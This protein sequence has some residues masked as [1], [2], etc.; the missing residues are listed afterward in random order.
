MLQPDEACIMYDLMNGHQ[1]SILVV[2]KKY[3]QV[4]FHSDD[5]F[6]GTIKDKYLDRM[7]K[8]HRDRSGRENEKKVDGEQRV[9]SADFQKVTQLTRKFFESPGMA[10]EVL[11]E[12]LKGYYR[13]LILPVANRLTTVKKLLISPNDVLNFIPFEALQSQD[14]KYLVEKYDVKYMHST[15]VLKQIRER[16][17]GERSKPLLAMGGA[18][19]NKMNIDQPVISSQEDLN[20]LV[21]EV[22]ENE[23]TNK[24]ERKAYAALFG[25]GPMNALPGTV[26]EV[27]NISKIVPSADFYLGADMSENRIKAMAKSGDLGKYKILHLATHGFVVN[28][29][30]DLSGVAMSIFETEQGGEDGFLNVNEISALNLK[31]D[32]TIL[33]A[34]QTALGKIYSGEGVTGLTQS[35]IIAGSNGALVSLWPVSDTSTMLFM[36]DLY[37][38]TA[39]GKPYAQVVNEI[40]RKFIKGE[41]GKENKHPNF[42]AP[43]V[44]FGN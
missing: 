37:K 5:N 1:I 42:W 2:T 35:L 3:A 15:S 28:E 4:I 36:S 25:Q 8:E 13:F 22:E 7:N 14:G 24:S 16:Q 29:I 20:M 10:D 39:A 18:Q 41:F 9:S 27:K 6:I 17:Y 40:K 38:Q 19:F 26:E 11:T 23:K 43:F 34:C 32:L 31:T 44:Y 21:M 33:S 12:Y 30:P